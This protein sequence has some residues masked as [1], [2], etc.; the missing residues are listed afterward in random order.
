[1]VFHKFSCDIKDKSIFYFKISSGVIAKID[2]ENFTAYR[3][4]KDT[5]EWQE[6]SVLFTEYDHGNLVGE[7]FEATENYPYGEPFRY[8]ANLNYK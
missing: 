7:E 5:K 6:D 8:K 4:N 2:R 1:M 3:F